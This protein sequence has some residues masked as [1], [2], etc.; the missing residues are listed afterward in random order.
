MTKVWSIRV[1]SEDQNEA[2]QVELAKKEGA[3]KIFIDKLSGKDLE[4]PQF[5]AMMNYV[6]EG[7]DVYFHDLSRAGRN[8]QDVLNSITTLR[9][10]GVN[11][12]FMAENLHLD[13]KKTNPIQ[14][15]FFHMMAAFAQCE[16]AMNKE[17]QR[18]GTE[19][20]KRNG[21][22]LGRASKLTEENIKEALRMVE[23]GVT[24]IKIA[25]KFNI[26]KSTLNRSINLFQRGEFVSWEERKR[27]GTKRGHKNP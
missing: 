5:Q 14:D 24:K 1:S 27:L 6:R 16:R 22:F 21:S 4:R 17:R 2:R 26:T 8:L 10:K 15:F 11:I 20:A 12:H 3:E 13:A 9:G 23:L 19:I 18:E 25:K 7:D